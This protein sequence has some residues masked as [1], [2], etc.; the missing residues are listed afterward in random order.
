[1]ISEW[2][3]ISDCQRCVDMARPGVIFEI[4]NDTGQSLFTPC[5]AKPFDWKS[6]PIMF[7]A[8]P[9]ERR[10]T[11]VMVASHGA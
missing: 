1:L 6:P 10:R 7:R 4:R 9:E 3:A 11:S 8:V 2:L 5:Q